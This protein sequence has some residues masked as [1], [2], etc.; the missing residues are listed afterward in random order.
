[1]NSL[2][3]NERL[4][5]LIA[6]TGTRLCIGIDPHV[7][8]ARGFLRKEMSRLVLEDFLWRFSDTL[9]AS[10][11]KRVPAIK[12]QSAFF[13]MHGEAGFRVLKQVCHSIEARGQLCL[14]DVKRGDIASTMTAYGRAAFDHFKV[15]AIT[16]TPY[17]GWDVVEPLLPWLKTGRGAYV[18][19]ITSN[20]SGR[21]IQE[22]ESNGQHYLADRLFAE[23]QTRAD[24]HG[25]RDALGW[26]LGVT[27]VSGLSEETLGLLDKTSL[28]LPGLG[29]Q[30]GAFDCNLRRVID[31]NQCSLL[32][33]SR[34]ISGMGDPSATPELE[35]VTSWSEYGQFV[36]DR[37][38]A[39]LV[40]IE[41]GVTF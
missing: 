18:V 22:F 21:F 29:P 41:S 7:D 39:A 2:P 9:L 20:E 28:L 12:V 23:W 38:G 10:A 3:F 34:A 13:E 1:M 5:A 30:G 14:L 33:M 8:Q 4:T 24:S 27:K 40:R 17:M 19:W 11:A 36:D 35:K 25:I 31:R 16:I 26:V 15:D 32:P 6:K 37:I